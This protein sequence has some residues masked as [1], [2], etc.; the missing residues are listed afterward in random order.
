MAEPTASIRALYGSGG[1]VERILAA[2]AADGQD[3]DKPTVEMFQH[4]DQLHGGGLSQTEALCALAGVAEGMRVLDAGCGIGGSSRY[5][6]HVHGCTVAAI[7]VTPEYVEAAG[8]LNALCGLDG[9]IATREGS[10][11][12]LPYPDGSFDLV[13]CQ[14]VSMN[15]ADKARMFAE[16]HR[17]LVP[18]GRYALSHAASGPAGE[19]HYPL[20]WARDASYSFPGTPDVILDTLAASGFRIVENR[21]EGAVGGRRGQRPRPGLGAGIA[22]GEDLRER[23]LN[24]IRSGEE[25]RLVGMLVIAE[26]GRAPSAAPTSSPPRRRRRPSGCG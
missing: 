16:A 21:G 10:V 20:P 18:G 13:W 14:N 2:L 17:V 26:R 7:D 23:L 6:A 11:T 8:R 9:R 24:S 22:L 4:V 15:V 1:L 12:D 19:P 5:L 3:V 25:G